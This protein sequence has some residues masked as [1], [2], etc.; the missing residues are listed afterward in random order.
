MAHFTYMYIWRNLYFLLHRFILVAFF[1]TSMPMPNVLAGEL[2]L[3]PSSTAP[4]SGPLVG[5]LPAPGTRVNLSAAF[6]PAHLTGITVHAENPLQFDFLIHK[7]EGN[8]SP[9]Q[10][11]EEYTKLIKYFLASLTVPDQ[12]QWVNLSPYEKQR[13][14]NDN[15]GKT[16]MGRDLLGQDYL[17][18]QITSSLMYPESGLGKSFW[19]K[20]YAKSYQK[21]GH[22]N[23]PVNT[24]NKVW[25]VPDE[26]AVYESGNTV[27]VLKSH[28]R[29]MLEEDYIAKATLHTSPHTLAGPSAQVV[30]EVILP[31]IEREVNEGKNFAPLRQVVSGMIL[32]AWYK[33]AL[34]ETLLGKVYAD[35]AKVKGV[36]QD[37]KTNERIY[38]NYLAAFKKGV[39]NYIKEDFDKYSK[40]VIPRKYFAGGFVGRAVGE[41]MTRFNDEN[42]P[43]RAMTAAVENDF[44]QDSIENVEAVFEGFAATPLSLNLFHSRTWEQSKQRIQSLINGNNRNQNSIK[45][46]KEFDVFLKRGDFKGAVAYYEAA[47]DPLFK[48]SEPIRAYYDLSLNRLLYLKIN[49]RNDEDRKSDPIN[50]LEQIRKNSK[51]VYTERDYPDLSVGLPT[52][53]KNLGVLAIELLVLMSKSERTQEENGRINYLREL[54]PKYLP[55]VDLN[56]DDLLETLEATAIKYLQ[57]STQGYIKAFKQLPLNDYP[58]SNIVRNLVYRPTELMPQAIQWA[59]L[60]RQVSLRSNPHDFWTR[61]NLLETAIVLSDDRSPVRVQ[62]QKEFEARLNDLVSTVRRKEAFSQPDLESLMDHL[63]RWDKLNQMR[64]IENSR[65]KTA[66]DQLKEARRW[67]GPI[68]EAAE[69]EGMAYLEDHIYSLNRY[70]LLGVFPQNMAKAGIIP[71]IVR[72]YADQM[73]IRYFMRN[74]KDNGVGLMDMGDEQAIKAILDYVE[75]RFGLV[76]PGTRKR[77]MEDPNGPAHRKFDERAKAA[78][79]VFGVNGSGNSDTNL[80]TLL[81]LGLGDCR[82]ANFVFSSL[83]QG[84]FKYRDVM[85][86][87]YP[88]IAMIERGP[89]AA[90]VFHAQLDGL[91]GKYREF[92]IM[93]GYI[94]G[95]L[96]KEGY[97]LRINKEQQRPVLGN[98]EL[99]GEDSRLESHT[100]TAEM[101]RDN[102]GRIFK[103]ILKDIWYKDRY[104]LRDVEIDITDEVLENLKNEG[105][106]I[107]TPVKA[108]D[109]EKREQ[110]E[111]YVHFKLAPYSQYTGKLAAE[112]D[113]NQVHFYG[114]IVDETGL[115]ALLVDSEASETWRGSVFELLDKYIAAGQGNAAMIGTETTGGIDL[116]A[117]NLTNFQIKRDGKG[118]ILP[119]REQDLAQFGQVPGFIPRIIEIRPAARSKVPFLNIK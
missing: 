104:N 87:I 119:L 75:T 3:P 97:G 33:K 88:L 25:I 83:V 112:T 103:I 114:N 21:Y 11:Q 118:V 23:I 5:S 68:P 101:K 65:L 61:A 52:A 89:E 72:N 113:A 18:K 107:P 27:Y 13:I 1:A 6:V 80:M 4:R 77:I 58:G 117:A 91:N 35:Q 46:Y 16:E 42:Q 100:L 15:F 40:Q 48:A 39:Y 47:T 45:A 56:S 90:G 81:A 106:L 76:D 102:D 24:F 85:N 44:A 116:N 37:P 54:F 57:E 98:K 26:A 111:I 115:Y 43:S 8:L 92:D 51:D 14:I 62:A 70:R 30:R 29:V 78:P 105:F 41:V 20:V 74:Y 36:D 96:Q 93:Q 9:E 50:P 63:E 84:Y 110:V 109:E 99:G 10:K 69:L 108:Y 53:T 59:R 7:G 82:V 28:F 86:N 67:Q 2:A 17:L 95:N 60:V 31:E 64:G 71:D 38:Q 12:D 55:E 32:A 66:I 19:D 34:K 79:K 22:T 49:P 94:Q 73:L